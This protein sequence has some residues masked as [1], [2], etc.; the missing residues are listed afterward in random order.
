[1]NTD[2][3]VLMISSFVLVTGVTLYF[4]RKVLTIP[5]DHHKQI[6]DN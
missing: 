5:P 1:M 3:L 4:F 2:A 6:K